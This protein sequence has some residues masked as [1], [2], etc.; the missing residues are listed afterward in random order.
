MTAA[1]VHADSLP[2]VV[3]VEQQPLV[4]ATHRLVDALGFVGTPLKPEDQRELAAAMTDTEANRSIRKIQAILDPYCLFAV[5]I[6]PES[7]VSVVEGPAKK[8]LVE[9]GWRTFLV[10]VLNQAGITPS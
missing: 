4:A 2:L 6:N 1:A 3:D 5:T 8:E 9:H 7:R 10:K